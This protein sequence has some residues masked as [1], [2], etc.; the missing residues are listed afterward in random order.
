MVSVEDYFEAKK[1]QEKYQPVLDEWWAQN[2]KIENEIRSEF[3]SQFKKGDNLEYIG[4]SRSKLVKKGERY[5]LAIAP[6]KEYY[7]I[8]HRVQ[9]INTE[10]R[11]SACIKYI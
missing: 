10:G 8:Y 9:V 6:Y 1:M 2:N 3:M 7:Y 11:I 5:E 4:N